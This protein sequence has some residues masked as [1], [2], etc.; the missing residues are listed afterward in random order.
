MHN[1]TGKTMN[2]WLATLLCACCLSVAGC[3]TTATLQERSKMMSP[4]EAVNAKPRTTLDATGLREKQVAEDSGADGRQSTEILSEMGARDLAFN[5]RL[6]QV[7]GRS[8]GLGAVGRTEAKA[9]DK[10]ASDETMDVAFDFFDAD[11]TDVVRL[12]MELLNENYSLDPAVKGK[13]ALHVSARMSRDEVWELFRGV[14]RFHAASTVL[15]GEVWR[16]L[17]LASIPSAI[18]EAG[19]LIAGEE[20]S[21]KRG[22]GV[23]MFRLEYLP[24][25]EFTN[26]IKPYLSP[27]SMVYGHEQSGVV[28]VA[29]YPHTLRKIDKLVRVF[30]VSA[31]AGLHLRVFSLKYV[32]AEDM[33][34]ELDALSQSTMIRQ[35]GRERVS[36]LAL[37][38]LNMIVAMT[39]NEANLPFIQEWIA[40]L[41]REAPTVTGV[42]HEENIFVYYVENGIAKTIAESLDGLF[43]GKKELETA[44]RSL[45]K[46][47]EEDDGLPVGSKLANQ[48]RE[49]SSNI[50]DNTFDNTMQTLGGPGRA[51]QPGGVGGFSGRLSGP[52]SFVV[53]ESTNSILVKC[54]GSDYRVIK[55]VIEK[56]DIFPR[57][58]LIEV[59]IAEINLDESNK[60]G[61]EWQY[62]F[63]LS[64]SGT[65]RLGNLSVAN[66]LTDGPLTGGMSY[67]VA[68]TERFKA[69]IQASAT[70]NNV[71]ILSSPHIL[72]SDNQMATIDIGSEVPVVT[73][74]TLKD[75]S[76]STV[77]TTDQSVQYRNTGIILSVTPHINEKG[78][79][80]ME[81]SQEVSELSDKFIEGIPSPIF[82]KR[83]AETTL[84]VKDGQTIVIGGLI[85]QSR[86]DTYTG[87]PGLSRIPIL[88]NL[89][90]IESK[91]WQNTELMLFITPHV[92]VHQE[93]TEFI[94]RKFVERLETVKASFN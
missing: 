85:R 11:I 69:A 76:T 15:D 93:D 68:N 20:G 37:P 19:I 67:L 70:D 32:K 38:R 1:R 81:V 84:S 34:K 83:K 42:E 60:L 2:L 56:L 16:I 66:L 30:D 21:R 59:L 33:I 40:E 61:V 77:T 65:A 94:S 62:I 88:R 29:D 51:S 75:D 82:S 45:A 89:M 6:T 63:D 23:Q 86:S 80:R 25:S 36:Y 4:G 44:Y 54:M 12:F 22:Q 9:S 26:V 58:V 57:Q 18:D 72:A 74:Q 7:M 5:R 24:V 90:G 31:F 14:L 43:N 3:Q 47:E 13:V 41:D 8:D 78:L 46:K 92:I 39:W 79:V 48:N 50:V 28:L 73:S 17:P 27:G 52:V 91:G 64:G 35:Q 55:G 71:Q 53:D 87:V 10:A 49:T